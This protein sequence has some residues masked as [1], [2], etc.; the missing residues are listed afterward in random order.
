MMDTHSTAEQ[1]AAGAEPRLTVTEALLAP[2][3]VLITVTG[4][5]DIATTPTLQRRMCEIRAARP[6]RSLQLD[7]SGL[8]FCDLA[9]LRALHALDQV[10]AEERRRVRIT[11]AARCLDVLLHLC[12]VSAVLGYTPPASHRSDTA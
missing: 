5:L 4:D 10:D 11:V 9:G 1:Y 12:R 7:L 6:D 3:T 8:L 2:G